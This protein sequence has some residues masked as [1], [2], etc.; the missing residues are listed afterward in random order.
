MKTLYFKTIY[1]FVLIL[2]K[3]QNTQTHAQIQTT[4]G[5]MHKKLI[6]KVAEGIWVLNTRQIKKLE[7]LH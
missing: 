1:H 2:P 4:S 6:K 5:R 3:K 7:K